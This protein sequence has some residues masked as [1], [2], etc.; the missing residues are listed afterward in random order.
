MTLKEMVS[1]YDKMAY[2][3]NYIFGFDYKGLV[4]A[5]KA[6]SEILEKVLY[7]DVA[8][9]GDGCALRFRPN[10]Q[11]K[12]MLLVNAWVVTTTETLEAE[13]A[14]TKYNRGEIFEKLITEQSGQEWVKDN[15]KFTEAGDVVIDGI[16]YQVKYNKATFTNVQT[17]VNLG[18]F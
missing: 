16:P 2:T 7:L 18:A 14:S 17:L 6:T 10:K 5:C 15:L 13:N 4:Y 11:V 1:A 12:E 8:S 9:R 3:H